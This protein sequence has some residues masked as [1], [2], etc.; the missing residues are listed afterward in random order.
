MIGLDTNVLVRYLVEDD[1]PQSEAASGFLE[2]ALE[3]GEMLFVP[4]IVTC[5]LVWVLDVAYGFSRREIAG[6]LAELFRAR[7]VEV[8]RGDLQRRAL[9]AYRAG[10]GDFADYVIHESCATAGCDLVATFDRDLLG[11]RGF[12][13]PETGPERG[14]TSPGG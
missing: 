6:V 7:Q 3:A 13:A 1:A 14:G 5:E 10:A 11:E 4:T 2:D 12:G 9:D 8:E